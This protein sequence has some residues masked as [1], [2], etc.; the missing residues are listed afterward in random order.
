MAIALHK[1]LAIYHGSKFYDG[2]G[3]EM[4]TLDEYK[5]EDICDQ[6]MQCRNDGDYLQTLVSHAKQIGLI[7]NAEVVE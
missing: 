6:Y 2:D 1:F 7:D 5:L 3:I 4:V